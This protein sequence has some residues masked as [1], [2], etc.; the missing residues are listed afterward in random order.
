[1]SVAFRLS[2]HARERLRFRRVVC[3]AGSLDGSARGRSAARVRML[4][5]SAIAVASRQNWK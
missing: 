3:R 4:T 5:I 2:R 1:M